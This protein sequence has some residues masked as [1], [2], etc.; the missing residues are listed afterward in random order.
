MPNDSIFSAI[1]P[2]ALATVVQGA[3][4]SVTYPG[5]LF[6]PAQFVPR[7]KIS[8]I[9]DSVPL[10]VALRP[11][12]LDAAPTIRGRRGFQQVTEELPFFRE[13]FYIGEQEYKELVAV[14]IG[15]QSEA[16]VQDIINRFYNDGLELYNGALKQLEAMRMQLLWR[17][18]II[19][20]TGSEVTYDFKMPSQNKFAVQPGAQWSN[21]SASNPINDLRIWMRA[22]ESGPG[23]SVPKVILMNQKTWGYIQDN[24]NLRTAYWA[25]RGITIGGTGPEIT[26]ADFMSYLSRK[27]DLTGEGGVIIKVING[28]YRPYE[29][30]AAI[31]YFADDRVALLPA[32]ELGKTYFTN[33][34]ES[35]FNSSGQN[36]GKFSLTTLQNGITL[37]QTMPFAPPF[38]IQTWVTMIGLPSYQAVDQCGMAIVA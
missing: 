8:Y 26:S 13:S 9:K 38:S 25:E 29:D 28:K 12:A 14:Q 27:L 10:A 30:S 4:E 21:T 16:Y 36:N 37:A 35:D 20:L 5:D 19:Q 18:G 22:M 34:P 23:N 1:S 6:F 2:T 31:P 3:N 32:K 24:V 11:S 7:M 17:G 15:S 33:T